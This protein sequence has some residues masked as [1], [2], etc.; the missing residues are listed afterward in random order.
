[1]NHSMKLLAARRQLTRQSLDFAFSFHIA[2]VD[3]C[4]AQQLRSAGPSFFVLHDVNDVSA[5][6]GQRAADVVCDAL[7]IRDAEN[8]DRFIGKL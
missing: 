7:A 8:Q 5:G 2:H 4:V 3:I 6:L 1:M